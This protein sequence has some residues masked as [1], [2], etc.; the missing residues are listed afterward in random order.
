MALSENIL[1]GCIH[2]DKT[3]QEIVY[4]QFYGML[5][6]IGMRY[7]NDVN[8]AKFLVNEAYFKIFTKIES[9]N[10][11]IAFEGWITRVMVN[12]CIDHW[13]K[14]KKI[15]INEINVSEYFENPK[16]STANEIGLKIESEYLINLLQQVPD[17]S[18]KVF[19]LFAVEGFSH[20][21]IAN[22][23]NINEGTSKWHVNNARKIL[24]SLILKLTS[25]KKNV[26]NS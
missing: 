3:C 1:N 19:L 16:D 8:D 12:T 23:L 6:A 7:F 25:E 2:R 21:E 15:K 9:Y 17:V 18:K 22:L 13:R 11:A 14:T 10:Q 5:L 4:Q 24:K 26:V 20:R